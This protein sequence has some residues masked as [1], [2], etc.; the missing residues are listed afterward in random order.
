MSNSVEIIFSEFGSTRKNYGGVDFSAF[1]RLDPSFSSFKKYFPEASFTLYTDVPG[2]HVDGVRTVV[3]SPPEELQPSHPR[4]G[5]R[6]SLYYKFYG[7]LHASR[8]V[9]IALDT[10]LVVVSDKVR[11]LIPLAQKFGLCFVANPRFQNLVDLEIGLDPGN[12]EDAEPVKYGSAANTST[13]AFHTSDSRG[14]QLLEK[15]VENYKKL[16][17]RTNTVV[18]RSEWETGI[19]PY[20]LPHHWC[21]CRDHVRHKNL[22]GKEIILHVGQPEVYDYFLN[23]FFASF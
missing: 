5:V 23:H 12:L 11:H 16:P 6:S 3:V 18:A 21:V 9:A 20:L 1:H 22:V 7:L 4:F 14:R 10:D 2:L 13:V 19:F 15:I 17:S 8:R